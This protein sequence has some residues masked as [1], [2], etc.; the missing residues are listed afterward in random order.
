MPEYFQIIRYHGTVA[1]IQKFVKVWL[2]D[3]QEI[4]YIAFV[5]SNGEAWD[6][7]NEFDQLTE[8]RCASNAHDKVFV[9]P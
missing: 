4:L 1:Y 9:A 8:T 3:S 2:Y 7:S 6:S 5:S